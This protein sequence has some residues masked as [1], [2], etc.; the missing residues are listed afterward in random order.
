MPTGCG[1]TR[2]RAKSFIKQKLRRIDRSRRG[3]GQAWT[4]DDFAEQ[5]LNWRQDGNRTMP[6]A[7]RVRLSK[8]TCALGGVSATI[9]FTVDAAEK[10]VR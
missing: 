7:D 2:A 5:L 1:M 6:A 9:D 4:A 10:L 8:A 3:D